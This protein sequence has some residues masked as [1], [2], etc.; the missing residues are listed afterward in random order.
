[1]HQR[2]VRDDIIRR[3]AHNGTLLGQGK[4]SLVKSGKDVIQCTS[5]DLELSCGKSLGQAVVGGI[6]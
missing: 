5:N 2:P 1:M 3:K 6:G 4:R